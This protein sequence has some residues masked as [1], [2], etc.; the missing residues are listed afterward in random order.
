VSGESNDQVLL[1]TAPAPRLHRP[2]E[3]PAPE[4]GAVG[5]IGVSYIGR[6]RRVMYGGSSL[7]LSVSIHNIYYNSSVQKRR[8]YNG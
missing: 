5:A 7:E 8:L 1:N 4:A 2:S 3:Q 6:D